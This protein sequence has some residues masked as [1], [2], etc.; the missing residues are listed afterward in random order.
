MYT[1]EIARIK[2]TQKAYEIRH[3]GRTFR[4][5]IPAFSEWF[6][7]GIRKYEAKGAEFELLPGMVKIVWP[8]KVPMLRTVEDFEREYEALFPSVNSGTF[9][10]NVGVK[11]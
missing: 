11:A 10:M 5:K 4:T 8:G 9:E 7:A 2:A 3:H 6:L 1:R